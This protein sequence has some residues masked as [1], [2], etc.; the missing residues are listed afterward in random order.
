MDSPSRFRCWPRCLLLLAA[1][2]RLTE[3]TLRNNE[4]AQSRAHFPGF[5][6]HAHVLQ[7]S[8]RYQDSNNC[9]SA[10]AGRWYLR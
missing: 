3:Q 2:A 5:W 7:V 9:P 4:K 10:P 6:Q 8:S 1:R